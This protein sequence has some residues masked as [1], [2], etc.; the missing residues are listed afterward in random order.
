MLVTL[1]SDASICSQYKV[2]G[3]GAWL[4]SNRGSTRSGG[5]FQY[6]IYDTAIAEAMAVVN[7]MAAGI[8]TE[9]I[10][11]GDEVLIQTDNNSVMGVLEGKASRKA[12]E[13]SKRRRKMGWR[14]LKKAVRAQN[15]DIALVSNA[16]RQ[17]TE[18]H[19]LTIRWRH[20]KAH[21]GRK[22]RRSAVNSFCDEIAGEHMRTA[23]TMSIAPRP[24]L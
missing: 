20:V 5:P 3:W 10:Q 22:D 11:T 1:F 8:R 2:G 16:F 15:H 4:K 13:K 9:I 6:S 18:R 7:G 12:N 21:Q 23:R 17:I 19:N 24:L 14:A